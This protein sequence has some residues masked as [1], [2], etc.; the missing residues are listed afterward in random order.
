MLSD[1]SNLAADVHL[2]PR[3]VPGEVRQAVI[4]GINVEASVVE[5]D[6]RR[7]V[8]K[9]ALSYQL[10]CA[11][12]FMIHLLSG[13]NRRTAHRMNKGIRPL[14]FSLEK[15]SLWKVQIICSSLAFGIVIRKSAMLGRRICL[16][17]AMLRK[18]LLCVRDARLDVY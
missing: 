2:L 1:F 5:H 18:R 17:Y 11:P 14:L 6:T 15:N 13:T 10:K 8:T 7:S 12:P 16:T 4:S 3:I 9:V